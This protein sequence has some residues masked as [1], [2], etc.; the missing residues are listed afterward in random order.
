M[1]YHRFIKSRPK[2]NKPPNNLCGI[3]S[4]TQNHGKQSPGAIWGLR[5]Q[6]GSGGANRIQVPAGSGSQKVNLRARRNRGKGQVGSRSQEI[7]WRAEHK[8]EGTAKQSGI[9]LSPAA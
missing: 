4:V 5:W 6:P 3:S 8:S 1:I 2:K 9:K 7:K